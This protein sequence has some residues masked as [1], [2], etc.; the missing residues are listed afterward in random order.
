MSTN[1]P[2]RRRGAEKP[3]KLKLQPADRLA[4]KKA[5]Q[6]GLRIRKHMPEFS[7]RDSFLSAYRTGVHQLLT[8]LYFARKELRIDRLISRSARIIRS[9]KEA[10]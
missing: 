10:A 5:M 2:Q 6:M 8:E 9:A 1:K 3:F 7:Y 4:A